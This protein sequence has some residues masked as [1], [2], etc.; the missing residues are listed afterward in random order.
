MEVG[1]SKLPVGTYTLTAVS[2]VGFENPDKSTAIYTYSLTED[3]GT[4]FLATV[5]APTSVTLE[6]P[7]VTI[8]VTAPGK[9]TSYYR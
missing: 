8:V 5:V 7:G 6:N 3:N 9:T 4:K 2:I 1:I